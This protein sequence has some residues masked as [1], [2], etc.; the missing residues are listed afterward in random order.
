MRV[1]PAFSLSS[2]GVLLIYPWAFASPISSRLN[3]KRGLRMVPELFCTLTA[4]LELCMTGGLTST[5]D[6]KFRTSFTDVYKDP[7][8]QVLCLLS[9]AMSARWQP[10][11]DGGFDGPS[12]RASQAA[13]GCDRKY[14]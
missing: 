5:E 4:D 6:D 1:R 14:L 12:C 11:A 8:L 2:A 3:L 10:A 13:L 9:N 7:G